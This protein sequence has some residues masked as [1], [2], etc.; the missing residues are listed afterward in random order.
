[1][2]GNRDYF[3]L[4]LEYGS[5]VLKSGSLVGAACSRGPTWRFSTSVRSTLRFAPNHTPRAA[6]GLPFTSVSPTAALYD[7][8]EVAKVDCVASDGSVL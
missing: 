4:I 6:A 8:R 7:I 5:I 1:M 3:K 2:G